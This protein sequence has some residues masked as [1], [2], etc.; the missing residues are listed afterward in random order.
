[1]HANSQDAQH[2][3]RRFIRHSLH[4]LLLAAIVLPSTLYAQDPTGVIGRNTRED[5][6]EL[7]AFGTVHALVPTAGVKSVAVFLSGDGAWN[8]GVKDMAQLLANEGALVAGID[9]VPYLM[10]LNNSTAACTSV[11]DDFATL[12]RA[13]QSR[14]AITV[15]IKPIVIGYS[16]GATLAYAIAAQAPAASIHGFITLGFCEILEVHRPLCTGRKLAFYRRQ[17]GLTLLPTQ[18]DV[19]WRALQGT[20]DQACTLEE[21]RRFTEA[22]PTARVI[23]LSKVGHGF[24][25]A[26]RWQPQ[27]VAAYKELVEQ[28]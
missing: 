13:I 19:P 16:S 3:T 10:A 8:T 11:A 25:V 27:Y 6:F 26:R 22:I 20:I 15:N 7:D 12:A 4:W 9:V 2:S 21:V 23:P 18:V 24:A 17:N 28:Y 5:T 1:L 14:Y